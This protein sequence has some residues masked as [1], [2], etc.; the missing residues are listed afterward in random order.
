MGQGAAKGGAYRIL[1]AGV[2]HLRG[3]EAGPAILGTSYTDQ[4]FD[5]PP[6]AGEHYEEDEVVLAW[7]RTLE[8]CA[9]ADG[10]GGVGEFPPVGEGRRRTGELRV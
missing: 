7:I 4:R 10:V 2:M 6:G 5:I 1:R 9:E 3:C 8:S